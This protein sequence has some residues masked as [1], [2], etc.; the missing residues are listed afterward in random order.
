MQR[1]K[2]KKRLK[3]VV[4]P[5]PNHPQFPRFN[6]TG[7]DVVMSLQQPLSIRE[8][9]GGTEQGQE[10]GLTGSSIVERCAQD[11]SSRWSAFGCCAA[12]LLGASATLQLFS[13]QLHKSH[14]AAV[15]SQ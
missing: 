15:S 8:T 1:R 5:P 14:K 13:R 7:F 10:G 2:K 11:A 6:G 9:L 12:A 4:Q 3:A